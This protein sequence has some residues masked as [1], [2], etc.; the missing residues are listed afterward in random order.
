[1]GQ[2]PLH[3]ADVPSVLSDKR[4]WHLCLYA[5][6]LQGGVDP[7]QPNTRHY[8]HSLSQGIQN[9][10]SK[11]H[12]LFFDVQIVVTT[13]FTYSTVNSTHQPNYGAH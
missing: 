3:P 11:N 10:A 13:A 4:I 2:H 7:C 12:F 5:I 9:S 1:M 6:L 8:K